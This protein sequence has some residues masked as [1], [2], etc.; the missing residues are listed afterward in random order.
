MELPKRLY[1]LPR[2]ILTEKEVFKILASVKQD[3][4]FGIRN[5]AL[6][7]LL[8]ATGMRSGEIVNLKISDLEPEDSMVRVTNGKHGRDRIIP[9]G[10]TA[11]RYLRKYLRTARAEF[12]DQGKLPW[13]FVNNKGGK[14]WGGRVATMIVKRQG[15]RAGI[16]KDLTAHTI[17]HTMATHLVRRGAPLRTSR[18]FWVINTSFPPRFTPA[19]CLRISGGFTP[20]TTP[21]HRWPRIKIHPVDSR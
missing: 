18:S 16:P 21:G 17:R 11:R 7:E 10:R 4:K 14:M 12:L 6:L 19:L 3:S 20:S 1:P 2:V 9:M 8:Y 15:K 13:L 5:K